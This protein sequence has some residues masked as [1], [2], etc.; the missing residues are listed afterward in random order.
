MDNL[1]ER[2]T[3]L[4]NILVAQPEYAQYLTAETDE[5]AVEGSLD[6]DTLAAATILRNM[7]RISNDYL[8]G[9]QKLAPI[10]EIIEKLI[11]RPVNWVKRMSDD[12]ESAAARWAW[13]QARKDK[14]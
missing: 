2:I 12:A 1:V 10:A 11:N 4:H 14:R 7:A 8:I 3:A 9:D 13:H 5:A 6:C